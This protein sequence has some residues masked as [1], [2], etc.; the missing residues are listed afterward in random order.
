MNAA[1]K[2]NIISKHVVLSSTN[3]TDLSNTHGANDSIVITDIVC[4]AN[5]GAATM[6][7]AEYD[8]STR[9]NFLVLNTAEDRNE[10]IGFVQPIHISE[11][12]RVQVITSAVNT[13]V[14]INYY[15][16]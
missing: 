11:G 3:W 4:G 13:Y 10:H 1:A 2:K 16:I 8:G 6:Q 14:T 9:T 15:V 5:V 7:F 12:Q